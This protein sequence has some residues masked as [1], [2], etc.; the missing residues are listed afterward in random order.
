MYFFAQIRRIS[1]CGE[2]REQK[3]DFRFSRTLLPVFYRSI[4]PRS[5]TIRHRIHA[6]TSRQS[7]RYSYNCEGGYHG[8]R[9]NRVFQ[10]TGDYFD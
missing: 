10:E 5:Q 2:L 1:E 8:T 4:R 7:Q 9:G 3:T 6:K